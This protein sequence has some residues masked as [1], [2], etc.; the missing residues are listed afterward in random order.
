MYSSITR[1]VAAGLALACVLLSAV[2]TV[3]ASPQHMGFVWVATTVGA[4]AL[5]TALVT[6]LNPKRDTA[7]F[8][9]AGIAGGVFLG[10][11][12][13]GFPQNLPQWIWIV[14]CIGTATVALVTDAD[15][16]QSKSVNRL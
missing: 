7:L 5:F 1:K 12:S 4:A 13:F 8:I 16:A 11:S 2:F 15:I 6:P 3:M 14:C 10:A 9:L